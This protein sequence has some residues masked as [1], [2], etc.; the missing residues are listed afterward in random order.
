MLVSDARQTRLHQPRG[1][2]AEDDLAMI[3]H[4]VGMGMADKHQTWLGLVRIQP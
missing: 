3:R 1:R 4:V 2:F